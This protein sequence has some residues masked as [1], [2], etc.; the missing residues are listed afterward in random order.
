MRDP[1]ERHVMLIFVEGY[2]K[3]A[4]YVGERHEH[5]TAH[6]PDMPAGEVRPQNDSRDPQSYASP[7]S[8][9]KYKRDSAALSRTDC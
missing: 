5:G 2:L 7:S 6:R 9:A 4:D 8:T 1:V 3:L